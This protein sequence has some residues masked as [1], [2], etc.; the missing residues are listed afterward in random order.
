MTCMHTCQWANECCFVAAVATTK[1]MVKNS[2][3]VDECNAAIGL[4]SSYLNKPASATDQVILFDQRTLQTRLQTVQHYLFDLGA[5]LA[6]PRS[7][8]PNSKIAKTQFSPSAADQLE[9]WIDDM[10]PKLRPLNTFVLPGGHPAAAALHMARTIARRAERAVT[11]LYCTEASE[12]DEHAYRFLNR[13][14]DFLFVASRLTNIIMGCPDVTWSQPS[15][16]PA[17]SQ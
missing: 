15:N 16:N 11:P 6:T 8:S 1:K 2:G 5:H 10:D 3:T 12:I 17:T 9:A 4:A 7:T 14:S 13:L